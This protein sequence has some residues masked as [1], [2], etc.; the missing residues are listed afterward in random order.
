MSREGIHRLTV[1]NEPD[2]VAK[3]SEWLQQ[4]ARTA[5]LPADLIFRID[6]CAAEALTN[7]I[8][9]AVPE[10]RGFAID[11]ELR[12][13]ETE[14]ALSIDD[15]GQPFNPLVMPEPQRPASLETAPIGGLGI[16]LLRQYSDDCAYRRQNERN[17][18]TMR[19]RRSSAPGG[20]IKSAEDDAAPPFF[21]AI[22]LFAGVSWTRI[23]PIMNRCP[24]RELRTGEVLLT[25][26][27][28]NHEVFLL[29]AGRLQA[30]LDSADSDFGF[31]I[32]AGEL[33]GEM[34]VID[35]QLTSAFVVADV[36]STV[37]VVSDTCLWE[38]LLP[39]P[40]ITRN[41]LRLVAQRMRTRNDAVFAA[42]KQRLRF[43]EFER[44]LATAR[45]LQA[46]MLP[47]QEP[48]LAEFE[49]LDVCAL[50]EP[51]KEV[52]GDFYDAFALDDTHACLVVGDVSG[53]GMPA[54][55]FMMRVLTL[56]R[57]EAR[58][59]DP[60]DVVVTRLNEVLAIDNPSCMFVTLCVVV[61]DTH[62]G[63]ALLLSG[64]H[65]A[66]IVKLGGAGWEFL[67]KPPGPLVGVMNTAK[68]AVF[69]FALQPAD[70][71][72]LYTDGVTEAENPV[73]A[74]YTAARFKAHLDQDAPCTAE[75]AIRGIRTRV[76]D[77][78]AGHA[79]SDD[80]TIIALRYGGGGA[81]PC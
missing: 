2:D 69:R 48:L 56:L 32:E 13:A 36:P 70:M 81:A 77:H 49:N 37:V 34:S 40:G 60:I 54:A 8:S 72:V 23:G 53:K 30:R 42:Q 80:I 22:T 68:F 16:H 25:P 52:G 5:E 39:I 7:V 62:T 12:L 46:N 79:Q 78:S 65:D 63:E 73:Q 31:A 33:V 43:E 20:A 66:P 26:G 61:V 45:E 28:V 59:G 18:L 35:G 3:A 74:Q 14:V 67:P 17:V 15:P 4:I 58:S 44:E 41:L 6:L 38:E 9:Y 19:W 21:A 47:H 55:L 75:S 11:L 10:S 76:A 24:V 64:G 71:L 51:A 1:R 57:A 29:L 27:Q 50:M